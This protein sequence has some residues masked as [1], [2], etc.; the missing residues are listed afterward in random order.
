MT[1]LSKWSK[2]VEDLDNKGTNSISIKQDD[3]I[4]C[5]ASIGNNTSPQCKII[6]QYRTNKKTQDVSTMTNDND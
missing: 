3:N 5:D 1:D 2:K 4:V 6:L